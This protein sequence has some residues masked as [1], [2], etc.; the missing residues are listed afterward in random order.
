[1]IALRPMRPIAFR[2]PVPAM[3]TTSVENSS[4]A[5]IILIMRRKTSASGL[6]CS[7]EAG[8]VHAVGVRRGPE[9]ADGDAEHQPD[10]NLRGVGDG[11]AGTLH[12]FALAGTRCAGRTAPIGR[13]DRVLLR[14]GQLAVDRNRQALARRALGVRERARPVAEIGEAGLQVE[15]HRVVDLVADAPRVE[16]ALQRV[17]LR[18]PDD[19][20]VEDVAAIRPARPAASPTR[21]GRRRGTARGS[22]RHS[23]GAPRSTPA[24][25]GA[26]TRRTAAC[27]ASIRKLPPTRW[28]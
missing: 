4:G 28:W 15:R 1:M 7:R 11:R 3:P 16:M 10:E 6:I 9:I 13:D 19:E 20:L 14:G 21:R 24:R 22:A 5:M 26:F 18:R 2:S 8:D 23:R 12:G 27:S 17:A 25:C